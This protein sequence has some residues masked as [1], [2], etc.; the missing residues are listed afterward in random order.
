MSELLLYRLDEVI[1]VKRSNGIFWT[2]T[3]RPISPHVGATV[4]PPR[5]L[6][7]TVTDACYGG[8]NHGRRY[9]RDEIRAM[10]APRSNPRSGRRDGQDQGGD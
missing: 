5:D 10:E 4:G 2:L 8:L 6:V 9:S 7:V 1:R 3:F